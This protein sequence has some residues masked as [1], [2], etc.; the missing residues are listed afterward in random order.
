MSAVVQCPHCGSEFD[1]SLRPNAWVRCATCGS[2]LQVEPSLT[3]ILLS[4]PGKPCLEPV[5]NE[6][7][8][9]FRYLRSPRR[10]TQ[11]TGKSSHTQGGDSSLRDRT[12]PSCGR[13]MVLMWDFDL[14][15]E[16]FPAWVRSSFQVTRLPLLYCWTCP[17]PNAYLMVSDESIRSF[18]LDEAKYEENP[19]AGY[20]NPPDRC[21][22]QLSPIP[23]RIEG[24]VVL[25]N[26]V[27]C[28]ALDES[29]VRDLSKYVGKRLSAWWNWEFSQL[30]GLPTMVQGEELVQCPNPLCPAS[31]LPTPLLVCHRDYLM[32]P[33][34]VA[35]GDCFHELAETCSQVIFHICCLC[36]AIH[37][38]YRCT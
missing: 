28:K 35:S 14:S 2:T 1:F 5:P 3:A 21:Y 16:A 7:R 15:D 26:E 27:G 13:P 31:G 18:K 22:I 9:T 37:V 25:A 12:C 4:E 32:R 11:S 24:L 34:A 38:G 17:T 8:G 20:T 6:L 30:G 19:L 36:T 23:S 29:A 10:V 33:F